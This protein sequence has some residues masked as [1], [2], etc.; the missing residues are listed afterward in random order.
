MLS[1]GQCDAH[2]PCS[3]EDPHSHILS[4]FDW[5]LG[6]VIGGYKYTS[7]ILREQFTCEYPERVFGRRVHV[8]MSVSAA[9]RQIIK[10]V[11]GTLCLSAPRATAILS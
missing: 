5:L 8:P 4:S 10:S 3:A 2:A 7:S 6:H 11:S 9:P 1:V